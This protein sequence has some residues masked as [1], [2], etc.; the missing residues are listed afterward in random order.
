MTLTN[1][2]KK[3]E[4]ATQTEVIKLNGVYQVPYRE[5]II[6]MTKNGRDDLIATIRVRRPN[7]HDDS[8][9]DYS[10]GAFF[11]NLSQAIRF[12]EGR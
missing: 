11:N 4:A 9:S 3:L 8:M 12:C 1:G 2:I 10:A 7:D 5:R 6:E